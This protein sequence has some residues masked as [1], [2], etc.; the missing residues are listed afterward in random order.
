MAIFQHKKQ[1]Q[2][3]IEAALERQFMDENFREELRN[4]GR[5]YFEKVIDENGKLFKADLDATVADLN[6]QLKDHVTGQLQEVVA[7]IQAELKDQATKQLEA[8][9]AEYT[10]AMKQAQDAALASITESAKQLTEQHA[11][12]SSALQKTIADQ[13]AMMSGAMEEENTRIAAM[14]NAQNLAL[15]SL[16]SSAQAMQAEY[17][18]LGSM[19]QKIV[20]DQQS[21]IIGA[22]ESNMAQIV[23]HYLLEALGD[24]FDLKA[25]LPGILKQLE[26][27]KQAMVDDVK[28]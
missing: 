21:M 20:T 24:Q 14:K 22:F 1:S 2:A 13:Q 10:A 11:Q 12:L 26:A 6:A 16:A 25:Q 18:Q 27:N 3:D 8:Q 17:Q 5:L 23:E 4:H 28:L 7:G 9:F 15:Q 19:L